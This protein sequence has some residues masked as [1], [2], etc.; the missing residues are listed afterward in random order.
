MYVLRARE[1]GSPIRLYPFLTRE[2]NSQNSV[3]HQVLSIGCN[4]HGL[5]KVKTSLRERGKKTH[6]QPASH[7][8]QTVD[9]SKPVVGYHFHLQKRRPEVVSGESGQD[10]RDTKCRLAGIEW[11]F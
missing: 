7:V 1:S 11:A 8:Y 3:R 2:C 5:G 4:C 10:C 6:K 9:I